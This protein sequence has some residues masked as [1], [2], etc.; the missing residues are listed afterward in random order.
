MGQSRLTPT[1]FLLLTIPPLLWAGN[2]IVGRLV[3]D[4]IPPIT[5][6]FLRWLFAFFVLLPFGWRAF[7]RGSGLLTNIR[8]YAVLGLLG[9]GMY[10]ALQYLALHTST[11]VNVTLVGASMP[12]W[13]IVIG[14]VFFKHAIERYQLMGALLSIF[15]VVVVLAH[16]DWRQLLQ[17]HFV[18]GDLYMLLATMFWALYSWLLANTQDDSAVRAHWAMFL[19]AQILYGV[20]WSGLS[21]GLEW[22]LTDWTIHWNG[23][24]VAALFYVVIGPA[25]V[26]YRCWGAGV[27]RAG[28]TIAGLFFNLTP[29]FAALFSALMLGE[30]PQLHHAL[31]FLLIVGGIWLSTRPPQHAPE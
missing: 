3:A 29:I 7:K 17:M 28:P 8:R 26:A 14:A 2:A 15:G 24:L 5:L 6:N 4:L 11:P 9:I 21:A 19:L 16:G 20:M 27:Q 12:I 25:V 22:A 1:T 10:N 13:M 31:A 23:V 18:I 30:H